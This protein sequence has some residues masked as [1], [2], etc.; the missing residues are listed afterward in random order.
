MLVF[1][2]AVPVLTTANLVRDAQMVQSVARVLHWQQGLR[3]RKTVCYNL[4]KRRTS[5]YL[6]VFA[7]AL[8][9]LMTAAHHALVP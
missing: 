2:S 4:K 9:T 8:P 7:S 5:L 3:F 6:N 1:I